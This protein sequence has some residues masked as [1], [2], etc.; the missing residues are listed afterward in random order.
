[1]RRGFVIQQMLCG[2]LDVA[3]CA[4]VLFD[5]LNGTMLKIVNMRSGQKKDGQMPTYW[6]AKMTDKLASARGCLI[7]MLGGAVLW[8]IAIVVYLLLT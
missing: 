4:V 1:M 8:G 5:L 3:M 7:G 2:F 6:R